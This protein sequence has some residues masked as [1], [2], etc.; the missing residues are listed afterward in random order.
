MSICVS[1][2]TTSEFHK[3]YILIEFGQTFTKFLSQCSSFFENQHNNRVDFPLRKGYDPSMIFMRD[4]DED[5]G[6]I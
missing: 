5:R 3:F 1:L 6:D 2:T 4:E